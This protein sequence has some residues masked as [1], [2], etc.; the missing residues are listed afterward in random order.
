[1]NDGP[2][3]VFGGFDDEESRDFDDESAPFE[4]PPRGPP[5]REVVPVDGGFEEP[6]ELPRVEKRGRPRKTI[7]GSETE[8]VG[9]KNR[10]TRRR[11]G[12]TKP[13]EGRP[14]KERRRARRTTRLPH[15]RMCPLCG[16]GPIVES[17]RWVVACWSVALGNVVCC[18]RCFRDSPALQAL[19]ARWKGK[20]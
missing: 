7:R 17:R 14:R 9:I 10:V 13:R 5:T 12:E 18:L 3:P 1:M 4:E 15:D 16:D 19:R 11:G 8:S 20:R 2:V 6:L